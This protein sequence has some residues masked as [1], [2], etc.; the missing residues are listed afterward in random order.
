MI[1]LIMAGGQSGADRAALDVAIALGIPHGGWCPKN[2]IA[3]DGRIP[4]IY[5]LKETPSEEYPMR[6]ELNIRDSDATVIFLNGGVGVG[7]LLTMDLARRYK[8]PRLVLQLQDHPDV[9]YEDLLAWIADHPEVKILNVAGARESRAPG[10]YT[11]VVHILRGA[12]GRERAA[13]SP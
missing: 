1:E 9:V 3:E 10:T 4:E 2:R 8:K 12:L 5:N 13:T 11:R 7:S 6:T